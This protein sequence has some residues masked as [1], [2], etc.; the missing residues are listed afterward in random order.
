[1]IQKRLK[2]PLQSQNTTKPIFN[3]F[4][5]LKINK[6]VEFVSRLFQIFILPLNSAQFNVHRHEDN[7]EMTLN[8][9]NSP[10]PSPS[11]DDDIKMPIEFKAVANKNVGMRGKLPFID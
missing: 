9:S 10:S 6:K 11:H 2:R 1:M 4:P 8:V 3:Q 5:R 7:N